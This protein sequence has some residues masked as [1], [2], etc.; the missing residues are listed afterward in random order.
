MNNGNASKSP[1]T[2]LLNFK[3]QALGRAFYR[4]NRGFEIRRV[5]VRHLGLGDL[6]DLSASDRPD[7]FAIRLARTFLDLRR[8][9]QKIGRGRCLGDE[10]KRA[11]GVDRD[12][13]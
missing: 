13:D 5:E 9:L 2:Y 12:D 6:L 1:P 3:T 11:I 4:A 10:R 8:L 7:L